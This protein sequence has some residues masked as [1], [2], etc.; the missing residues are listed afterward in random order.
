MA[1]YEDELICDM[2]RFYHIYS[3]REHDPV[4][5]AT[6]FGG[7]GDDSRVAMKMNNMMC[8]NMTYILAMIKDELAAINYSL[9]ADEQREKP[10]LLTE[11]LIQ[12]ADEM[13]KSEMSTGFDSIESFNEWYAGKVGNGNGR[14]W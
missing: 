3:Y 12:T 1:R 7:L 8:D 14:S 2:A 9:S 11:R 4:Y 10:E 6:L 13:K 5:I